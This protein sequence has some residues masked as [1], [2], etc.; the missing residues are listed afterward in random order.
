MEVYEQMSNFDLEALIIR[1]LLWAFER[2]NNQDFH[3]DNIYLESTLL[4]IFPSVPVDRKGIL[5]YH[6]DQANRCG[7]AIIDAFKMVRIYTGLDDETA[8]GYKPREEFL[9]FQTFE[10]V[11]FHIKK[12]ILEAKGDDFL[13]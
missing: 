6:D 12:I 4:E 8:I 9:L 13:L 7:A 5:S 3:E 2:Y 10:D 1:E 11:M